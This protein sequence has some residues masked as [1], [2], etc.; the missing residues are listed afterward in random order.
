MASACSDPGAGDSGEREMV[1]GGA[2]ITF[3]V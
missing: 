2:K 1:H 3:C